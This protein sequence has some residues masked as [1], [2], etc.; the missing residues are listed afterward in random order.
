MLIGGSTLALFQPLTGSTSGD[1]LDALYGSGAVDMNPLQSLQ[2]AEA[3]KTADISRTAADPQVKRDLDAF[4]AAV[5]K[6]KTPADLLSNPVVLKVLLTANGLGDQA[7]YTALARKALLSDPAISTSLVSRLTDTRW[8]PVA[9]TYRFA[10]KGLTVLHATGVL[11]TLKR[12][13][14][15]VLWR[16]SLDTA[17]PGLSNAISFRERA[18]TITSVDQILGDPTLRT[19]V[20]TALGIP[21][22]IAFQDLGA[23]EKSISSRL[24]ISKFKDRHFVDGLTQRYLLAAQGTSSSAKTGTFDSLAVQA[25]NL[26]V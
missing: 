4:S 16:Q 24:D 9:A 17:T 7:D 26:V 23:Q 18:S 3:G 1:I 22:E 25:M 2:T 19:V 11:P 13:Y 21:Q 12:A 10:T 15:E 14:A 20:T 6:A 8:K 5:A